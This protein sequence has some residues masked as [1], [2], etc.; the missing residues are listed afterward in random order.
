MGRRYEV[1]GYTVELDDDLRVVYRNPRGKRLQQVPDWLADSRSARRLYRLRRALKEHRGQA[2]V[3]A[4]SW[5]GAGTRVPMAL[6]ESDI[7]WREALD[8]AGVEPVADP[9]APD[10][11]ETTLVAR[12]YVHPDDHTMTLLLNTPFARHWDVLLASREEWA[13]TDTFATGIRAPADTGGTENTEN[14]ENTGDSELPFPERLMAAHPGQEQEALEAAYAF[15]WSLWGS[16]SLY[17]SLLD[18]DVEDLAATAPRFLPAFLDEL[19]DLCLKEGGKHKQYATGYFTRA[20]NAERE[21]HA[22]PD[23]HWLDARY[24]TFA[25]HGALAS[26]AV[27][28]R[29]KELAPRGA[30]VSPDQLQRFRDVLVRR[31][32]TPHDLYPGM[33]AD[34]RKVARAAGANPEAEVAA[35]LEGI[36][37]T[38]GLCA[39]DTDKFWVDALK[40]KALELLVE[41]RPETVHDV[42]RLLPDDANS[43]EE[44][45]SLLQRSGALAQLTGERPG[46]PD[47]EAARLL[48]NWLASEPTSRVRS[49][50]LYDL[51]VR[52]APRLAADAVPVRLPCPEPDRMRALIPLDL[53][54]ELLEHGVALADPPPGLGGAGI[55]N[56]LVHRRPQL[57]RLL[58]DPRFAR[59]LRNALDAELELVGLPDAGIS[60]HRHYRPHRATEHNSWQSTPGICRTPL[61]REAL[62][63]WLDRQRARLRAGLDLNGLVRVL[64]PF[65][66]V[67]GVVDELLKDEAAAREFAAVDVAALVLA[68]LPIQ[69]DRPAVEA[70][71][72]TMRPK[73][74]I[75]TR[76]MPDL[77]TRI[78]ETLPDLSEPQAAEAWKVLQTGVNC[79]EGLR[80]LVA[81]LSG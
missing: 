13:L 41:R 74:L 42:L 72:A 76:P 18:N 65:V 81:R 36:V 40:G 17:K 8:D 75:G 58:A 34:L 9:P 62:H 14:T 61:G 39:G 6:A 24:A 27:R 43:A 55:A 33:A 44:W 38:I 22:K 67:G 59:E 37:P 78:D 49:D 56:M 70:L 23:E 26:G 45:L 2:R 30:T 47:G 4:E 77:R 60:Y 1:D 63:A 48:R 50:E 64:A 29:A 68:D 15:G 5:A 11:E 3:L 21:Q 52:L 19:A 35:L 16:P 10:A 20:R 66:H 12:T 73:D 71:M 79:Q 51:A 53:A 80:R 69:A 28:A 54:D 46:L 25:D 57:T 31:V 7:V 32:H